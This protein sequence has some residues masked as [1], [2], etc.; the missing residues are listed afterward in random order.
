MKERLEERVNQ[1]YSLTSFGLGDTSQNGFLGIGTGFSK[2]FLDSTG[3]AFK[4]NPMVLPEASPPR[5][6]PFSLIW[7]FACLFVSK[8]PGPCV[9]EGVVLGENICQ[10]LL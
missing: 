10:T 2:L 5:K 8:C 6:L 1:G 9:H 7:T 3:S 4:S